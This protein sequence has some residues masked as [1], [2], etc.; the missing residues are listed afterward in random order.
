MDT[1]L[2]SPDEDAEDDRRDVYHPGNR[3]LGRVVACNGSQATIS[4]VINAGETTLSELWSVGRL[5]S[6]STGVSRI[7]ALVYSMTTQSRAWA[8]SHD[9]VMLVEV[10][11]VGEVTTLEDG[12]VLFHSGI[13][14]YP[15]LGAVAHRMRATDLAAIYRNHSDKSEVI[16]RLSQDE[17]MD[18][19]ISIPTLLDRHFAVLGSTG[20]GKSTSVSHLINKAIAA[21]PTLRVLILDPHNEFA[22]AFPDKS[23]VIEPDTMSLP[24][25]LFRLEEFV[26]VLFRGRPGVPEEIDF[27]H[28]LIAEAKRIF[29]AT[30]DSGIVRRDAERHGISV[31]T[32]VPYRLTD[33]I[34]QI[35]ERLGKLDGKDEKPTL[36][37]LKQRILSAASNPRFRFMFA[38]NAVGDTMADVISAIFRI[39]GHGRP[40]TAFQ[41]SGIPSEVV[42]AVASV[43]CRL[44]FELGVA[45]NG[46][47]RLLVLCEEAHRY[48]PA[49]ASIGFAPT[50]QAIARIAKEGRKYGV[51]LG[52]ITQRPGELDATI[53]SQCSTVFA[54][55]LTND[56][57]QEII[58]KAISSSSSSTIGFLSS[59]DNGEAIAFG[60]AIAVPM[61]M[62]F[63]RLAQH[64]LPRSAG[65]E[66]SL[67]AERR[68]NDAGALVRR[69]RHVAPV[70]D[71]A[72]GRGVSAGLDKSPSDDL[73]DDA[74]GLFYGSR[75]DPEF[76]SHVPGSSQSV[77][78]YSD[79][80]T[81]LP[82]SPLTQTAREPDV[83]TNGAP[84]S[85]TPDSRTEH[86]RELSIR[87]AI[88]GR[89]GSS[90]R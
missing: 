17:T 80:S 59:L 54:M 4:A 50:R 53:L 12:E 2:I 43:L 38:N 40:I 47:L 25:W 44:A 18:A 77:R 16:G 68:A 42:N 3:C 7:A 20:V 83:R 55:R 21:E 14:T 74:P 22:A 19:A 52:V 29:K 70:D 67:A 64:R 75:G 33:L 23:V 1:G 79:G 5:V 8:D 13:R 10:E 11:L 66:S 85:S 26:E 6:I 69:M 60:E 62:R 41:L 27:L 32:P 72:L 76:L 73:L 28:D 63:E 61:R 58:A 89:P 88:F 71:F 84:S 45:A 15:H 65:R 57:D 31:D 48:V 90:R 82:R 56:K 37:N 39:P 49:D 46:G 86:E 34:D 87:E 24:F 36:R 30:P 51:G 78:R 35:D 9:N 81:S